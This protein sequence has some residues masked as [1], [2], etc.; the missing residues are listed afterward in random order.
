MTTIKIIT[1]D[2][3]EFEVETELAKK[4]IT[5]KNLLDDIEEEG[6]VIPLPKCDGNIFSKVLDYWN[7][8]PQDPEDLED[9]NFTDEQQVW[10][11]QFFNL[12]EDGKMI[13][14]QMVFNLLLAMDYLDHKRLLNH[15]CKV[16]A[17]CI[18]GKTP[19]Q[20]SEMFNI[21][22]PTQEELEKTTDKS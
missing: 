13:D 5:I 17:D 20:L 14:Q 21:P 12:G 9:F 6:C 15:A 3:R 4:S 2:E 7:K 11:K 8:Y 10:N 22:L 16:V 1:N 19:Q 18:K